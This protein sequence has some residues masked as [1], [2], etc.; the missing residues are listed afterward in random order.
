MFLAESGDSGQC[1]NP[2][3]LG[4]GLVE[5]TFLWNRL[6]GVEKASLAVR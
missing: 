3:R 2:D 1:F 6:K 4:R 5:W